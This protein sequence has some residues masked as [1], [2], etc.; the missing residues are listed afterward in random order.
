[1]SRAIPVPV[2]RV[3]RRQFLPAVLAGLS[4]GFLCAERPTPLANLTL[5]TPDNLPPPAPVI[6][7][8]LPS[9]P[10]QTVR[11]VTILE[12]PET[13][14]P[15]GNAVPRPPDA[16][17]RE[18]APPA[19]YYTE[20]W[21]HSPACATAADYRVLA[22]DGASFVSAELEYLFLY[23]L[24][25]DGADRV[26]I[27][28]PLY[29]PDYEDTPLAAAIATGI[30]FEHAG[31]TLEPVWAEPLDPLGKFHPVPENFRLVALTFAI[32]RAALLEKFK[33]RVSY[34]QH[35]FRYNNASV[36]A[37]FP[38]LPFLE[39]Y[40]QKLALDR[41]KF[42][43]LFEVPPGS[44]LALRRITPNTAP[45][46]DA[47]DKILV[48]LADDEPVAVEVFPRGPSPR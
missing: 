45:L 13:P 7:P 16:K 34:I 21:S 15:A 12:A 46:G 31:R 3:L 44:A 28:V 26:F 33:V 30:R 2:S 11:S 18:P 39:K 17:P 14:L 22:G 5:A 27:H 48:R 35:H 37:L 8:A 40:R 23:F 41:R 24:D 32:P 29:V 20:A 10:P 25:R 36:A 47:P 1:M 9:A 43:V 42:T 38:R 4:A 19:A 6:P